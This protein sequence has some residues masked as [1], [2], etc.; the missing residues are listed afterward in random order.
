MAAALVS[1]HMMP[2][3]DLLRLDPLCPAFDAL[4]MVA[5]RGCSHLVVGDET[6]EPSEI[7]GVVSRG[8]L[9]RYVVDHA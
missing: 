4:R 5:E 3:A 2:A 9:L 1:E 6:G 8:A 7:L